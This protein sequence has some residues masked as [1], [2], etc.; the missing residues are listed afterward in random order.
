MASHGSMDS[1]LRR[2]WRA[3]SLYRPRRL[4]SHGVAVQSLPTASP[5][6]SQ[7]IQQAVWSVTPLRLC[8]VVSDAFGIP[9]HVRGFGLRFAIDSRTRRGPAIARHASPTVYGDGIGRSATSGGSTR[10][11]LPESARAG[12]FALTLPRERH[13]RCLLHRLS[14]VAAHCTQYRSITDTCAELR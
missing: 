14:T 13:K 2:D 1:G 7:L 4:R 8:V 5:T 3:S 6:S 9:L 11:A 10:S 12:Q